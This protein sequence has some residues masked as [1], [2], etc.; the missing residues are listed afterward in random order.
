MDREAALGDRRAWLEADRQFHITALS[1][2]PMPQLLRLISGLWNVA[3]R[4]RRAYTELWF[5][6][7]QA[8]QRAEHLLLLH[9]IERGDETEAEGVLTAHIRRTRLSLLDHEELFNRG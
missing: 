1:A 9:A 2:A 8:V 6:T 3:T 7:D 5:E 4:Y